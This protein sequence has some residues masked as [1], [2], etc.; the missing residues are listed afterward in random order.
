MR[1]ED[2]DA[3][4]RQQ[5]QQVDGEDEEED[6]PDVLD[7]TVRVLLEEGLRDLLAQVLADRFDGVAGPGRH[8]GADRVRAAA[9]A[10]P[11]GEQEDEEQRRQHHHD[12]VAV[13]QGH[14]PPLGEESQV[15]GPL[16]HRVPHD[17]LE[18]VLSQ[19]SEHASSPV[20]PTLQNPRIA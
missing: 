7:E 15:G 1:A 13:E 4:D 20:S 5:P 2:P 14:L 8:Q 17:V 18:R 19:K 9:A 6:G 10:H 12:D 11:E 3:A 16:D